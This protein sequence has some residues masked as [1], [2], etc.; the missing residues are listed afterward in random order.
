[1]IFSGDIQFNIRKDESLVYDKYYLANKIFIQFNQLNR[2]ELD[3][4]EIEYIPLR[5]S[6]FS[7]KYGINKDRR[8]QIKEII[9]S[10]ENYLVQ[11]YPNN[12]ANNKTIYLENYRHK[13]KN[14]YLAQFNALNCKF[15]VIRD[16]KEITFFDD[17][18]QDIITSEDKGYDKDY[19]E[20]AIKITEPDL[21]NDNHKMCM[22]YVSGYETEDDK[23]KTEIMVGENVKQQVIFNDN[24]KSIRYLYPLADPK[25]E[26]TININLINKGSYYV[27]V[28]ANSEKTSMKEYRITSSQIIFIKS[29]DLSIRCE[30]DDF[31][32]I[33][34]EIGLDKTYMD[35]NNIQS[36]IEF[37][38][39]QI[40]NTPSYIVKNKL[41]MDY[42]CGD[43]YYYLYTDIGKNEEGYVLVKF[44]KDYGYI[45]GK[46]AKKNQ[47]FF[48]AEADFRRIYRM[49]SDVWE[50]SL[51]VESID[52]YTQKLIIS[53][54]DTMDCIEGCY[55]LLSI[56]N[57]QEDS[58][59]ID[60]YLVNP[61]SIESNITLNN[62]GK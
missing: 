11:I 31:C 44:L 33:I 29:D 46:V 10:G 34:V 14:A 21:T 55:L 22:I 5:N 45:Y 20:Y 3:S 42:T 62:N 13:E 50:D 23:T 19:Y 6:I 39:R 15:K 9:R 52:K 61:I 12:L 32:N 27:K 24:L 60:D 36:K 8:K 49:P 57:L 54:K 37:S 1:M 35:N 59:Y 16:E 38:I 18:A 40:K 17:Y 53:N 4:I 28:Y 26:L 58:D 30:K 2:N 25:Y 56:I 48:E 7:I 51:P 43:R 47:P 41:I